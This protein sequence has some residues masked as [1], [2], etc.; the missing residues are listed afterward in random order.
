[1]DEIAEAID[2]LEN[3]LSALS[4]PIPD[5]LHVEAMRRQLPDIL[6]KVRS[7]YLIAGGEDYWKL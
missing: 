2:T 7:G 5:K 1:M 3:L 4:L 6:G